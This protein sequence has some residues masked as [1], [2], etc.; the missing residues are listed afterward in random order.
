M[1]EF[2]TAHSPQLFF[3]VSEHAREGRVHIKDLA[4]YIFKNN[5]HG[6]LVNQGAKFPIAIEAAISLKCDGS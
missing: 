5:A 2:G 6:G 4:F 1:S 3:L